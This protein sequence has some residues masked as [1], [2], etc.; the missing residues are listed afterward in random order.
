MENKVSYAFL[1]GKIAEKN[2][3]KKEIASALNISPRALRNKLYGTQ[4][5]LWSEVRIMHSHFFSDVPID[6]LMKN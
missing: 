2:I 4:P 3:K 6:E 5:F 1:C